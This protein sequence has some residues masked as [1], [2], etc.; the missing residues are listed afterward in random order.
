MLDVLLQHANQQ[1]KKTHAV[2]HLSIHFFF[3]K[4]KEKKDNTE[5]K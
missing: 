5:M 2:N 3:L 4:R 1:C